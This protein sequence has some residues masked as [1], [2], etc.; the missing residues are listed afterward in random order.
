MFQIFVYIPE[1][2]LEPVK[3]AMFNAG[4]GKLGDYDCCAWQTKGEGQFRPLKNSKPFLGKEGQ[5]EKVS[6]Y[7]IELLCSETKLK[8]T[9]EAMR[10]AHPYEEPAF[11]VLPLQPA[12]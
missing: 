3:K 4:A 6:E 12:N 5:I 1:T 9:I 11:G 10:S 8:D 2:H 7:R